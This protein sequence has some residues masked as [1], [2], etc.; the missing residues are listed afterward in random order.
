MSYLNCLFGSLINFSIVLFDL[1][2]KL[3]L[4]MVFT[5][6]IATQEGIKN[7]ITNGPRLVK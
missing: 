7:S 3:H 5:H 6:D 1:N 4:P 2:G